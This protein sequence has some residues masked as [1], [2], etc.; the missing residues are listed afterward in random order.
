[1]KESVGEGEEVEEFLAL[2]E[3]LDFDGAEGNF[4]VA[5]ERD[6][7]REMGAGAD[8]DGDAIF[9]I[10]GAGLLDERK[11]ALEDVEDVEG[12]LLLSVG[13][14]GQGGATIGAADELGMDVKRR[15]GRR[16]R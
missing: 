3:V 16:G 14:V 10:G 4:F 6:E 7:L 15:V 11:L 5:E 13:E 2:G 1:M 8:E 12:F 9:G